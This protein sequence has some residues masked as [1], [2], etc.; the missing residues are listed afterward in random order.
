MSVEVERDTNRRARN[1]LCRR[2]DGPE[3]FVH[4]RASTASSAP[5]RSL[6]SRPSFLHKSP[7]PAPTRTRRTRRVWVAGNAWS[8]IDGEGP[9]APRLPVSPPRLFPSVPTPPRT[10]AED[11]SPLGIA[12]RVGAAASDETS[13]VRASARRRWPSSLAAV[14]ATWSRWTVSLRS[15]SCRA[16]P[17]FCREKSRHPL[18]RCQHRLPRPRTTRRLHVAAPGA[19]GDPRL[20][21]SKRRIFTRNDHPDRLSR[22]IE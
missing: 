4:H 19:A 13:P 14:E 9:L 22:R 8:E 2:R 21:W 11:R 16:D 20:P 6:A 1:H 3:R 5:E 17:N 15:G 12:V 18:G 7:T 10:T